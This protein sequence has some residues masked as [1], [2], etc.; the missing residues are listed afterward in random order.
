MIRWLWT[1]LLLPGV[2]LAQP[3]WREL[4]D[5][6][7]G[8]WMTMVLAGWD[9]E[10][11]TR[12]WDRYVEPGEPLPDRRPITCEEFMID[13]PFLNTPRRH[14]DFGGVQLED[15]DV[16]GCETDSNIWDTFHF[17]NMSLGEF[18]GNALTFEAGIMENVEFYNFSYF[19][20]AININRLDSVYIHS[21][22]VVIFN[23]SNSIINNVILEYI[24]DEF[25]SI[26]NSVVIN[27]RI[28][29]HPTESL[30]IGSSGVSGTTIDSHTKEFL[31]STSTISSSSA[32]VSAYER[33]LIVR[34]NIEKT[35]I[36]I[37]TAPI[38]QIESAN[39][40][41]ST[42]IIEDTSTIDI[43]DSS[44]SGTNVS[45]MVGTIR[46]YEGFDEENLPWYC[47]D[48]PPRLQRQLED[49]SLIPFELPA[50]EVDC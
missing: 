24:A 49:G 45:G 36:L 44:F 41:D 6:D 4:P 14:V 12:H 38:I 34:S 1:L 7:Y 22:D 47:A 39:I 43:V 46:R 30:L 21:G 18:N 42:I 5:T 19:G 31:V 20:V 35:S 9:D 2:A 32:D 8:R 33:L 23:F 37:K 16:D 48:N 3:A 13:T 27:S 11:P 25:I 17:K 29:S 50:V 26:R 28:K 15:G 40:T 10:D